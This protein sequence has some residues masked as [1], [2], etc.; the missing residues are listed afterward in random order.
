MARRTNLPQTL[1]ECHALIHELDERIETL[2]HE[3]RQLR[4]KVQSLEQEVVD[5]KSEIALLQAQIKSLQRALFGSRRERYIGS[6]GSAAEN[7]PGHPAS[8]AAS[9]SAATSVQSLPA[10]QVRHWTEPRG[11]RT[12]AGR[13]ARV[14][15]PAWPREQVRHAVPEHLIPPDMKQNPEVCR[16]FRLVREDLEIL[17]P[18]MKVIQHLEEVLTLTDPKTQITRM[19]SASAPPATLHGCFAGPQLLATLG[20]S[21]FADHLPYYRE[22]DIFARLD[23]TL[24]RSTQCRWMKKLAALLRPLVNRMCQRVRQSHVLGIDE[25]PIPEQTGQPGKGTRTAYLY[26]LHGDEANPYCCFEYASQ[27]NQANVRRIVGDYHG[28]MQTDAYICYELVVEASDS[29]ITPAGCWAHGRRKFEPLV[30]D[31]PHPHAT[32][33]L[34]QIQKLYDIEERAR[35]FTTAERLLLRQQESRPIVDQIGEWLKQRLE[36]ETPR[37]PLRSGVNYLWKRWDLFTR[38]L[39]DGAIPLDNNRTESQIKGPV[40]GKK[41]WLFFGNETGGETAA[42][43]YSLTMTCRRLKI[44]VEA[45]LK[46]VICRIGQLKDSELDAL[47]PDQ[48]LAENPG[49]LLKQRTA[50]SQ[51][52]IKRKRQRRLE[53]RSMSANPTTSQP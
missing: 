4:H 19:I 27:K 32:W 40:M 53:R 24:A 41:A 22:E 10:E 12:S 17:R 38:F 30:Q 36:T 47:L 3:N 31:G 43:M 44:D 37:S 28:T 1:P 39:E 23:V 26:A 21:R 2:E 16:F 48:W 14:W 25:T 6:E 13:K 46:D 45:Y 8:I 9:S 15:D 18:S 51:A 35:D 11:K 42:V 34:N 20:A 5:L 29:Q 33:I 7:T 49:A 52:A 50:E